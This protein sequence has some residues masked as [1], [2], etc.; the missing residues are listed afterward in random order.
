MRYRLARTF[1]RC[2]GA[3]S[4]TAAV[5]LGVALGTLTGCGGG[6]PGGGGHGGSG[7]VSASPG[8]GVTGPEA[9][10]SVGASG[11][12]AGITWVLE[13]PALNALRGAG[14]SEAEVSALFNNANTYVVGGF[15]S[16]HRTATVTNLD[17]G[18]ANIPTGTTA[19]LYDD[20]HWSL[21]PLAQQ[22]D[23][24]DSGAQALRL[25]HDEGMVLIATPAPDLADVLDPGGTGSADQRFLSLDVIASVAR[26]ADIVD[27]QAQGLEGSARYEQFV[28]AA[29]RQARAANPKVKVLAGISTNPSGRTV[30][31]QT[32]AQDAN[33]VRGVVDGYWLNIPSAGTACPRCGVARPRVALPWLEALLRQS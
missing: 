33:E 10:G 15:G 11:S 21:T 13:R 5:L 18:S 27:I 2:A 16:A 26:N 6:N 30:S 28:T 17:H 24:G 14:L 20:E 32:F 22:R 23:P 8:S 31:A 25:A 19:L 4:A 1:Q 12:S 3:R 9:T 7:T 29:A